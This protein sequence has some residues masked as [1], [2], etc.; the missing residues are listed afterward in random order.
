MKIRQWARLFLA[1]APFMAG[2]KGFWDVP[3]G[4]GGGGGTGTASG[5]F[6]VLNQ[7]TAEVAGFSFAAASTKLTAVTNSPYAL[8]AAPFSLAISPTGGFLYL[9]TA[10]GIFLYSVNAS[11]G[12]SFFSGS[13]QGNSNRAGTAIVPA[14]SGVAGIVGGNQ[15]PTF[16]FGPDF[17]SAAPE[18]GTWVLVAVRV[19]RRRLR[20]EPAQAR[21]RLD[22]IVQGPQHIR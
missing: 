6:Y 13:R 19:V 16:L 14:G 18:L 3:S 8:G 1:L 22:V 20:S 5:K 2:C 17:V 4:S 21:D 12:A 11:T 10:G 15:G 7:K 9:S